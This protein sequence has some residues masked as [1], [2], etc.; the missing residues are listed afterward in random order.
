MDLP[1]L[2]LS[3]KARDKEKVRQAQPEVE[4][5]QQ[6]E[7][8][9]Q[10]KAKVLPKGPIPIPRYPHPPRSRA[11]MVTKLRVTV[12]TA[13]TPSLSIPIPLREWRKWLASLASTG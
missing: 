11:A 12:T 4:I 2:V 8:K 9:P 1:L 7:A 5:F 10:L 3:R 13:G 6:V